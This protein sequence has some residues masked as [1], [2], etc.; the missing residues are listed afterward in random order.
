MSN[1]LRAIGSIV[2][3][4][5]LALTKVERIIREGGL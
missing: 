2:F 4:V 3:F 5:L 1:R